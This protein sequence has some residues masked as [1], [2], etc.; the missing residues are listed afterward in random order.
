MLTRHALSVVATLTLSAFATSALA[1]GTA[2]T[3]GNSAVVI[4]SP[5][6]I[7]KT[8]DMDFG[9]VSKPSNA[10][11]NTITMNASG[12]VTIGGTGNGSVSPSTTSA[13]RFDVVGP[14]GTTFTTA[15]T[16]TLT[17]AGL[18]NVTPALPVAGNG[19]MG[20]I[21]ASGTQDIQYGGSFDMT[22]GTTAQAYT[23]LLSVTITYN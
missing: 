9:S 8:H 11:T 1:A 10:N 13:G 16:L 15:Q 5:V 21:P 18:S 2:S 7:A 3:T 12:V 22:S 20:T 14:A 6:T 23:G 4:M 19:T 17:P